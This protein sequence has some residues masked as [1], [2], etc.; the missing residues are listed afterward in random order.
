MGPFVLVHG[1]WHDSSAFLETSKI[2]KKKGFSVYTPTIF[3]N[4]H[5][6][7]K[8]TGLHEAISSIESF[9]L[10]R[11]L[12]NLILCGHSYG[13][14]IITGV[15][16]K[17]ENR[18]K[19][20][21]YWNAFVP[22]NGECL[23]DMVSTAFVDL[24][25]E[26]TEPDGS[27][28]LPFDIWREHFINDASYGMAVETYK[29]LNAHPR[30]TFSDPIRLRKN[31]SEFKI[32]KSFINCLEDT[33]LPQS[34]GWHPRLSEKLGF[35]RLIQVSGSHEICYTNPEKLSQAILE[36]GRD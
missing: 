34:E 33:A 14:M 2:L 7:P 1:A 21:V 29:S 12:N 18:I 13:G 20:L 22:N 28:K 31:P 8:S 24:L 5:G 27:F 30:K 15:A 19:R 3:G 9:I 23:E 6:D 11:D 35:F 10:E 36:A 25:D 32:G 17:L 16:D 4:R 26:L